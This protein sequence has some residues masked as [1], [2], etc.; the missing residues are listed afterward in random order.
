MISVQKLVFTSKKIEQDLKLKEKKPSIVNQNSVVYLYKCDLC[1]ANYVGYTA[2]HLFQRISEHKY[3]A[4]GR[5]LMENHGNVN[6]LKE[7]NFT[8]LKKCS[9][10][11][12]CLI[13]EMLFIRKIRPKLNTQSDSLK[14]KVFV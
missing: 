12:D 6:F 8:V 7:N 1:D 14:A 3:S 13:N 11:W 10:K 9:S 4:I 5:H 2:R